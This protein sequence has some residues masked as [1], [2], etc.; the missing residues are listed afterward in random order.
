MRVLPS[1]RHKS[2]PAIA[3][4]KAGKYSMH[5]KQSWSLCEIALV[6]SSVLF[7]FLWCLENS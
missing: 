2:G 7:V 3:D 6:H 4:C 1:E 5:E